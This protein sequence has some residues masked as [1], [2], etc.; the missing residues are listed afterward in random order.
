VTA[1]LVGIQV[2]SS[3]C[4][5]GGIK[6]ADTAVEKSSSVFFSKLL[7]SALEHLFYEGENLNSEVT[8]N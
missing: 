4:F 7:W 8:Q 6:K 3:G 1:A 5:R 2:I